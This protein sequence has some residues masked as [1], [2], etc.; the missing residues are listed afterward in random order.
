MAQHLHINRKIIHLIQKMRNPTK[1]VVSSAP[2]DDD[3]VNHI[4]IL[5]L[6]SD[7][8]QDPGDKKAVNLPPKKC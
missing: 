7:V 2:P 1:S 5:A 8:D 4:F 6:G 3:S